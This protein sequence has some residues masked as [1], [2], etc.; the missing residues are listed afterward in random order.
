MKSRDWQFILYTEKY[1]IETIIDI[2]EERG[3]ISCI[4]PIH[5]QDIYTKED[6]EKYKRRHE[7]EP[8]WKI[9]ENKKPHYHVLIHYNGPT[10]YNNVKVL[11]ED[12]GGTIPQKIVNNTGAYKYLCHLENPDKAQYDMKDIR[13]TNG[14]QITLS[15][16]EILQMTW[17]VVE[18]IQKENIKEY[19]E[20]VDYYKS[21]GD[22]DRFNLVKKNVSFFKTYLNS[23]RWEK[24]DE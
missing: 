4:S 24:K 21:L 5:D 18:E 15:D 14:Y 12:V 1:S 13:I 8:E 20:L 16:N 22:L 3:I 2:F 19:R 7:E 10:T 17:E 6:Y 11:T 23:K 9:G